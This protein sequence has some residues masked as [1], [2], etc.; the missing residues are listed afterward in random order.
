[1]HNHNTPTIQSTMYMVHMQYNHTYPNPAASPCAHARSIIVYTSFNFGWAHS[2]I[3][4]NV[5][6]CID[7]IHHT[8]YNRT[9]IIYKYKNKIKC[10]LMDNIY[11][12]IID[13]TERNVSRQ[14]HHV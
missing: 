11:I 10:Y 1:M 13:I 5:S 3:C 6:V 4:R 14:V 2:I 9:I 7:Y 12:Y 8:Q